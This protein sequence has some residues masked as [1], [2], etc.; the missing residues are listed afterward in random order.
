MPENLAFIFCN[1][2]VARQTGFTL[3]K[4][5]CFLLL[6]SNLCD[7]LYYSLDVKDLLSSL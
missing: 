6:C 1:F 4:F 3:R 5:S 2:R 7:Y